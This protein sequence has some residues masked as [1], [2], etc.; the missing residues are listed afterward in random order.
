MA[1][2]VVPIPGFGALAFLAIRLGLWDMM[3]EN[4]YKPRLISFS[5]DHAQR[6]AMAADPEYC[7]SL[8]FELDGSSRQTVFSLTEFT[9][10]F[11]AIAIL[12][13]AIV[14]QL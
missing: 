14:I 6:R 1:F 8:K 3:V 5:P 12:A 7:P 13:P 11:G 10:F 4:G 2:F 9:F